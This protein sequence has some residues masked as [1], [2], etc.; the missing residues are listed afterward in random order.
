MTYKKAIGLENDDITLSST[1]FET[2]DAR[3]TKT[4]IAVE[5]K[6]TWQ[7]FRFQFLFVSLTFQD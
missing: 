3:V 1:P 5:M 7:P 4:I 6:V 2:L